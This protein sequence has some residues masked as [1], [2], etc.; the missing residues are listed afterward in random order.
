MGP[1]LEC[2]PHPT[3]TALSSPSSCPWPPPHPRAALAL[4]TLPRQGQL[5]PATLLSAL[6]PCSRN[7]AELLPPPPPHSHEGP[8]E[9]NP[10]LGDQLG[11]ALA[12]HGG[13][14]PSACCFPSCAAPH[15]E[16]SQ[17]LSIPW[18]G[19]GP[20]QPGSTDFPN[21][22]KKMGCG[23]EG[24]GRGMHFPCF[25]FGAGLIQQR[26]PNGKRQS[27][28]ALCAGPGASRRAGC[29]WGKLGEF[30]TGPEGVERSKAPT[31]RAGAPGM[32]QAWG[33][34]HW[35]VAVWQRL[36]PAQRLRW[37]RCQLG[38]QVGFLHLVGADPGMQVL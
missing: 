19:C 4:G 12:T 37:A 20:P 26:S 35:G 16:G 10:A 17:H 32:L 9:P 30:P 22:K 18:W 25:L 14:Q 29:N 27:E 36:T 28:H 2:L 23:K 11:A 13:V 38:F 15:Q 1:D 31:A 33:T 8:Q 24:P 21:W 3:A 6:T 5:S 7:P 34:R